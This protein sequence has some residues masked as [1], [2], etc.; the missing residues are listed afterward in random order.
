M[1]ENEDLWDEYIEGTMFTINTKES[2]TM[3]YSTFFLMF[4]RN[5]RLPFGIEKLEQPI[6]DPETLSQ[7]MQDLSSEETIK[8]RLEQMLRSRVTLF[9]HVDEIK[10]A[11]EK[12]KQQFKRRR[13]QPVCRFKVGGV[14]LQRD[15]LEMTKAGHIYEDH[16]LGPYKIGHI[17]AD[18]VNSLQ[19]RRHRDRPQLSVLE[20]C[21][22]YR[23]ST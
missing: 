7:A 2:T 21:L 20:R 6:T 15:M 11:Q 14:V 19:D 23:E 12:Q 1:K 8:E 9:P 22:A 17:N 4:G 10:Q 16:W 13:G 18:K 3:K 5:P